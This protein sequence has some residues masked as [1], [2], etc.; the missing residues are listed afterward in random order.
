ML[1]RAIDIVGYP[2]ILFLGVIDGIAN[3]TYKSD[4][5]Q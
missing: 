1:K 4:Y 3:Y 2:V 5:H